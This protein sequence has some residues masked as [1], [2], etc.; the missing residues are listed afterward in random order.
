MRGGR[1]L[2]VG[3][4]LVC[5]EDP[6]GLSR[7]GRVLKGVNRPQSRFRGVH[8]N[9]GRWAASIK[10][11]GRSIHLGLHA[12]DVEA[13]RIYDRACIRLGRAFAELNFPRLEYVGEPAGGLD[14]L[15]AGLHLRRPPTRPSSSGQS[16]STLV[17]AVVRRAAA[18]PSS[19]SGRS[20]HPRGGDRA[21]RGEGRIG[22]GR[23]PRATSSS[24]MR[25]KVLVRDSR[26]ARSVRHVE[27]LRHQH[28]AD[29]A[30]A[31]RDEVTEWM[32]LRQVHGM[33]H[34]NHHY[35]L[36][37]HGASDDHEV[38]RAVGGEEDEMGD[39]AHNDDDDGGDGKVGEDEESLG[40][41]TTAAA[42]EAREWDPRLHA[43]IMSAIGVTDG[44]LHAQHHTRAAGD[45]SQAPSLLPIML[46]G[47]ISSDG[48]AQA[49][50]RANS[51]PT[52]GRLPPRV[53][54]PSSPSPPPHQHLQQ[55]QQQSVSSSLTA[56]LEL[57]QSAY[58]SGSVSPE[59]FEIE[60]TFSSYLELPLGAPLLH[61]PGAS[62]L[63]L[64][65]IGDEGG[66]EIL[67]PD[68]AAGSKGP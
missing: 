68:D 27:R 57:A 41:G 16:G 43:Q 42:A 63:P 4:E 45:S 67:P 64:D 48:A 55:Q 32:T 58:W 61:H 7:Q 34:I 38:I 66:G 36:H 25:W 56:A 54:Y 17:A 12:S 51:P 44:V 3:G 9:H 35:P 19:S 18:G 5:A 26:V 33:H 47:G 59:T 60:R 20:P 14:E 15:R 53:Q 13:A 37:P 21:G 49:S 11:A 22:A 1:A 8:Y 50:S 39:G 23:S 10:H 30:L 62:P 40:L 52:F 28:D 65:V 2:V 29:P 46:G 31:G 6:A 24:I